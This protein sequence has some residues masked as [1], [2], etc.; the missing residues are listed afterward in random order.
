MIFD[1]EWINLDVD[2]VQ[3]GEIYLEM[4]YYSNKPAPAKNNQ[5]TTFNN[6]LLAN[7]L[8]NDLQRRPSKLSP[9]DRLSRPRQVSGPVPAPSNGPYPHGDYPQPMQ[10]QQPYPGD[11]PPSLKPSYSVI[12]TSPQGRSD[13]IQS[14]PLDMASNPPL[15][16]F[17]RPG[18]RTPLSSSPPGRSDIIP[19]SPLEIASNPPSLPLLLR[20]GGRTPPSSSP[21]PPL[22]Q[23]PFVYGHHRHPTAS[24]APQPPYF[25]PQYGNSPLPSNNPNLYIAG[26]ASP[27]PGTGQIPY[28]VTPQ[29]PIH[30]LAPTWRHD[31]YNS[32]IVEQ[33]IHGAGGFAVT[34]SLQETRSPGGYS[35]PQ[36]AGYGI[37]RSA[38]VRGDSDPS[39]IARYSSP[40][41]LPPGAHPRIAKP[42]APVPEAPA[43]SYAPMLPPKDNTPSPD[44]TRVE[45]LSRAEAEAKRRHDQELRDLEVAM[46]L[47]RELNMT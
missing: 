8:S 33:G 6:K 43:F 47:D 22:Y 14:S 11:T 10:Q 28:S 17:L 12:G 39:L 31:A 29:P 23:Q 24:P 5:P 38:H 4:T 21:V 20:P 25:T 32:P 18:G 41:P 44:R 30:N 19:S 40:L 7:V 9:A 26:S 36:Q 1:P 35:P 2:G 37:G 27:S 45:A 34:S 3:R 13:T 16:S 42:A 46:K 15:P